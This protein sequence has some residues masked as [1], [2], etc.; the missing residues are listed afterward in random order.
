MNKPE[1]MNAVTR[2]FHRTG[3]KIKKHSPEILIVAGVIG[4]VTSAVMACKATLK[5]NDVLEEAKT[6][7]NTIHDTAMDAEA[8]IIPA[9]KYTP[10]DS[11]KD[12]AIV[13][14]QTGVKLAK[15]YAPSVALGALSIFAIV[16][17]NDILRKRNV[18]L[19]AAYTAVDKG[20]KDY[21]RRVVDRFGRDL[22]R[23][24]RYNLKAQE[25]EETVVDEDG[26]E[27]KVKET[28]S[29]FDPNNIGPYTRVFDC[30]NV[31]W[32][33]D[34]EKTK[35]FLLQQQSFAN[36]KL[37]ER[38]SLFLNEVYDL[39]GYDRTKEGSEIGWVYDKDNPIGDNFVD[40]GLYNIEN[41]RIR[42]FMNAKERVVLLEFNVHGPISHLLP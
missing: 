7:I 30:G 10:E 22:D 8:G 17:S 23:E 3:F 16:K 25:V 42:S 32:D 39:L 33:K 6:N 34:P 18:A 41:E 14:M 11:K 21:R 20:F 2:S 1:F 4:T 38:G 40:F 35:F 28:V 9:E 24:L 5:V 19:V 29:T 36:K 31:G 37:K 27:T 12:L 13:Y 26:N 15:L